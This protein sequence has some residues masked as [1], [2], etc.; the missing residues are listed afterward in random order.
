MTYIWKFILCRIIFLDTGVASYFFDH[1]EKIKNKDPL[2]S[3]KCIKY[4]VANNDDR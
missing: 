3:L 2:Y 4:I 1:Y